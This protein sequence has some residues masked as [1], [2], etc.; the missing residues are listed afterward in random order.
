L[1]AAAIEGLQPWEICRQAPALFPTEGAVYR[2][3]HA[4]VE[5]LR[6]CPD[7]Y[8]FLGRSTRATARAKA[9]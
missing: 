6:G 8:A 3:Q 9:G 7:M 1:V 5:R 2:V 4:V